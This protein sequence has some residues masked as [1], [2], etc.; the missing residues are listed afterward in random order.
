ML[1]PVA[2]LSTPVV[3]QTYVSG[4]GWRDVLPE[5][6]SSEITRSLSNATKG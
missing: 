2:M 3:A 6:I 1:A 5:M 4:L